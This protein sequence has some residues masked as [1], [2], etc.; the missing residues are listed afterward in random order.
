MELSPVT[1]SLTSP[2]L[3]HKNLLQFEQLKLLHAAMPLSI[4]ATLINAIVLVAVEWEVVEHSS[5]LGWLAGILLITM[6]RFGLTRLFHRARPKPEQ[7]ARWISYFTMCSV[8]AGVMWG[9]AALLLFPE[10]SI[11]H[12]VFL[13]FIIGGMCAGAVTTLSSLPIPIFSF[14]FVALTPLIVRFSLNESE[15]AHAMAGMLCLFLIMVASSAWRIYR[16]T[17]QN[18]ELRMHSERQESI[19]LQSK[20]QQQTIFD[21]APVGIWLVGVDGRYRFVNKTFCDAIGV[22]ESTFLA[23]TNLA[24]ILGNEEAANCLRSDR[25][26]LNM[27]GPHL[28]HETLMFTDGKLHLLEI[29]KAKVRDESGK[30]AGVVGIGVDVSR[31]QLAEDKFRQAQKMEALGTLVGGIAHDFNNMLAGMTGNLYLAKKKATAL[32]DVVK[33]LN[34]VEDLG[35]QAAEMIKQ[36]LIF[37]RKGRVE[38]TPFGLTSFIKEATKLNEAIIPE[39]ISFRHSC[40]QKELVIKGDPTQLQ[41]V[42]MNLLKNARDAVTGMPEPTVSLTLEEFSADEIFILKHPGVEAGQGFAHLFVR[43]NGCGISESNQK[44]IFEPF[45]TTKE[46]GLGTGLG[47]SMVY[48]S[49]QAHGGIID[50]VSKAA[51]GCAFHLY[52]PLLH[53]QKIA[54][55]GEKSAVVV[56]GNGECILIVDDHADIRNTSKDVLKSIGYRVLLAADGLEAIDMFNANRDSISLIIMDVVMPRLGGVAAIKRIKQNCPNIKVIFSTGYDKDEALNNEMP[57]DEYVILSKPHNI[58][59]L[60]HTIQ[61]QLNS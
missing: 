31:R 1:A 51:K 21:S 42:L 46:V 12:Q 58:V 15:T 53:E 60:S 27:E 59:S 38:M 41:Q 20:L 56:Q 19:I 10:G 2:D 11:V 17:S 55:A 5:S 28:S 6:A 26:C 49:I 8:S 37:A 35:F 44:H 52:L 16:N 54:S 9:S 45:F 4:L 33:R 40:C 18:I 32:P 25:E 39:N 14:L 61:Q 36:M 29:T 22:P 24:E 13:A 23:N 48:G 47:L 7:S 30:I 43:D 34:A 57:S 3:N 50:V